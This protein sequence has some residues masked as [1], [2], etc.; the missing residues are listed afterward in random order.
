MKAIVQDTYG[1]PDVLELRDIDKPQV[2]DG[3][4]LVRVHAAG[5]DPG[6]W[7]LMAGLPRMI[8]LGYG[9]RRPKVRVRG[10]DVA[11]RIEAVGKDVRQ[12]QPG[13]EV[14]GTS[15]DGSFAE[16]AS[17]RE[18]RFAPKPSNLTFEQ[19]AAVPISACAALLALRDK[20][21]VQPGE[22]V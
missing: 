16:Y 12:F 3:D 6:V 2:G 4:V 1:S 21:K 19:A 7:H 9:L 15:Y 17:A 11:G 14:F 10:V 22:K 18:S 20:A 5:V 13:D 8:R